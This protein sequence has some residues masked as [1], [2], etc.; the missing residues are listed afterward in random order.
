[1]DSG[2]NPVVPRL[3]VDLV[4]E[5][6]LYIDLYEPTNQKAIEPMRHFGGKV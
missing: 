1:M 5:E 3:G 4:G 2:E 6:V